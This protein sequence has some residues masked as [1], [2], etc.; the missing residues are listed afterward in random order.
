MSDE[1]DKKKKSKSFKSI[2]EILNIDGDDNL[3]FDDEATAE[4]ENKL[5]ATQK[6]VAEMKAEFTKIKDLPDDDFTKTILKQLVE[7]SMTMLTALQLEIEDNPTGRSVETAATMVSAINSVV[8]N[9]NKVKV[10][11]QKLA[12]EQEKLELRKVAM[13]KREGIGYD[14]NG[15]TNIVMVGDTNQVLDILASKGIL[16][17]SAPSM[18]DVSAEIH[19]GPDDDDP[20][21]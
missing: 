10:Y 12:I 16:P 5:E 1:E 19:E 20:T 3:E 8:D 13:Q 21:S 6:A 11:N 9:F 17:A 4:L 7:K 18:K 14:G 15:D 2:E